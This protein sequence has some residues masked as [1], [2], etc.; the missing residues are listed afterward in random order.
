MLQAKS[1]HKTRLSCSDILQII[2]F[3]GIND[4]AIFKDRQLSEGKVT[5][6]RRMSKI[7][8]LRESDNAT[9]SDIQF[10]L[11]EGYLNDN[12]ILRGSTTFHC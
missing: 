6:T 10:S 11:F 7:V 1:K 8:F 5:I 12:T 3:L 2:L 9:L 4:N